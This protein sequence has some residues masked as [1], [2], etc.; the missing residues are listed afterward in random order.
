MEIEEIDGPTKFE[1]MPTEGVFYMSLLRWENNG[2]WT[3][4]PGGFD[5]AIVIQNITNWQGIDTVRIYAVR[6]PLKVFSAV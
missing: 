5:K 1:P 6:V 2:T 4:G 3:P